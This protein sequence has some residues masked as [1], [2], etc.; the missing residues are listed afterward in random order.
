MTRKDQLL[1]VRIDGEAVGSGRIAVSHLMRFLENLTKV[2][3]RTGRV[4]QGELDSVRRGP[5]PRSIKDEVA[6]DLTLL[7][8]GSPATI[9]GFERRQSSVSLPTM[10]FG[11]EILEKALSGLIEVQKPEGELPTG[12]DA[13][14]LMAWRDAGMLFQQG[15]ESIKFSLNHRKVPI[16]APFSPQGFVHIQNRIKQPETNIR[17]IEGRLLMADFKEHGTRCRVHPSA[18]EPVFCLFDEEHKEEVLDDILHY[19]RI[20][21]EAKEDPVSGRITSIRIHDIERLEDRESKSSELLPKGSPLPNDFWQSATIEEL[22]LSQNVSPML[23]PE[24][25]FG[26]WP[27]DEDD[28]FEASIDE[29][30]HDGVTGGGPK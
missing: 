26:T 10:D 9:L 23:N 13:G 27:G 1:T 24:V 14:V 28:N 29:L 3:Q 16:E 2:L 21:G 4:L 7:S 18:S 8:H 22:A 17:T 6:L 12:C 30:R 5:Q 15:I 20:V 19:V 25:L 11:M